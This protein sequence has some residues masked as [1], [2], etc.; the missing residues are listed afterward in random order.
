MPN[1]ADTRRELVLPK[2]YAAGWGDDQIAEQRAFTAG[3]I[4][5]QGER[6][7]PRQGK[8]ADY[9]LRY[10][11][12]LL[13]AVIE[14]KSTGKRAG[15]GLQQAKDYAQTLGLTSAYATTANRP[16]SLSDAV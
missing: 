13:L 12:D 6:A 8:R 16:L 1:E 9:L 7:I 10:T 4:V 5:V 2:L 3:R 15:P 14:A 11:R